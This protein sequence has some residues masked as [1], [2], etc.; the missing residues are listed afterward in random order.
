MRVVAVGGSDAG[1]SAGMNI[2]DISDLDLSYTPPLGSPWAG[3]CR[4]RRGRPRR[5]G[6]GTLHRLESPDRP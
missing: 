6:A 1:I 3:G 5:P 4:P 2:D